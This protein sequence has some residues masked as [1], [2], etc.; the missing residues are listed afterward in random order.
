M[1]ND[2]ALKDIVHLKNSLHIK[3]DLGLFLKF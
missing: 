1:K 2:D 3:L